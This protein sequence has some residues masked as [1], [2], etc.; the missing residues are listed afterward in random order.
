VSLISS[1]SLQTLTIRKGKRLSEIMISEPDIEAAVAHRCDRPHSVTATMPAEWS[2]RRFLDTL[3]ATFRAKSDG[4]KVRLLSHLGF[5]RSCSR[6]VWTL[7]DRLRRT[8]VARFGCCFARWR[9]IQVVS[10]RSRLSQGKL[11][12]GR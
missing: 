2:R 11:R 1:T 8:N 6:L 7:P 10:K 4:A 9:P 3:T 5:G 12:H